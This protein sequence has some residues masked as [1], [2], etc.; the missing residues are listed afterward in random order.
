M[1]PS[2]SAPA[3]LAGR[4]GRRAL[5]CQPCQ[6]SESETAPELAYLGPATRPGR[7]NSSRTESA[8]ISGLRSVAG[9]V[10]SG[11]SVIRFGCPGRGSA[12]HA[13]VVVVAECA[14]APRPDWVI[15]PPAPPPVPRGAVRA[16]ANGAGT[17]RAGGRRTRSR[18]CALAR[19]SVQAALGKR[20][21]VDRRSL[22]QGSP[23]L[24][25]AESATGAPVV[26][27]AE[28][29]D[30]WRDLAGREAVNGRCAPPGAPPPLG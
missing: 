15:A 21:K 4:V 12:S 19:P 5:V 6:Y 29:C 26:T 16:G 28:V 8:G 24:A 13:A 11:S 14:A 20:R 17:R 27:E 2:R 30:R 7:M 18:R 23:C 9:V 10:G 22:R 3:R 25:G 1:R